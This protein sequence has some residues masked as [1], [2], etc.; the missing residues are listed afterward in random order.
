[1]DQA[2]PSRVSET[3]EKTTVLP[4]AAHGL[5]SP[6]V[7]K[8]LPLMTKVLYGAPNLAAGAMAIPLLINMPKFYADVV[9]VPLAYLA[10]AIAATRCLDAIIDP[11]IGLISDRTRSRWGRRRPYIFAGAPLGGLAF[12]ALMSPP[13]YLSGF[14]GAV[15]F[16]AMSMLC[17]LFLTITLLP[18]YALGAELSLD[19]HERN[20]LFGAREAFGVLGTIIAAAA[21]GF[22]MQRFGWG[23][24]TVFSQLGLAFTMPSAL[25]RRYGMCGGP[26]CS[27]S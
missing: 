4:A 3:T 6:A 19:Y 27:R 13:A 17:S 23:D 9:A 11:S 15:W 18:H 16:T 1:M 12:W 2:L 26:P 5:A 22:L 20:S 10:I 24:R 25:T 8:P 7:T 21:P 14:G